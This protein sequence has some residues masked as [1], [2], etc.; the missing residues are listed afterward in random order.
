[1]PPPRTNNCLG[2][3]AKHWTPGES[4]TRLAASIG[5]HVAAA[6]HREFVATTLA[7]FQDIDA[8]RI[9]AYWPPQFENDFRELAP[10]WP[11]VA[12]CP[13]D[14]GDRLQAFFRDQFAAGFHRVV[15][16]GSDSPNL[17]VECVDQAIATLDEVPIVLGPSEDG[18][19]YLIGAT[20]TPTA[21][22]A[23]IPWGSASVWQTTIAR[24]EAAKC[25][26]RTLP[27]WYDV[28]R[29]HDLLR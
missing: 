12:Q 13:G 19:Y 1:M 14:L 29:E 7:R 18:G 17:P 20:S 9:V 16:V 28:D 23:G 2:V 27:A 3:F 5:E 15:V 4:K 10:T 6:L 26:Y 8:K 11:R 21:A 24:L 22:L 25:P